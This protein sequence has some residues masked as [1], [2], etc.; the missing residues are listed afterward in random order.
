MKTPPRLVDRKSDAT[1]AERALLDKIKPLRPNP[2]AK[3][4]IAKQLARAIDAEQSGE[5]E[6]EEKNFG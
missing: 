5:I 3:K 2:E 6:R 4:R 1:D